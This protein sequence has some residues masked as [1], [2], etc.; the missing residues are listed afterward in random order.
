MN[1]DPFITP[2]PEESL[3][4]KD[5]DCIKQLDIDKLLAMKASHLEKLT[6]DFDESYAKIVMSIA[7]NPQEQRKLLDALK[8]AF[9]SLDETT[10]YSFL[11]DRI[12]N[13]LYLFINIKKKCSI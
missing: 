11:M 13:D 8:K 9:D 5:V 3:D 1:N 2:F 12:L 7:K 6:H 4:P 10:L